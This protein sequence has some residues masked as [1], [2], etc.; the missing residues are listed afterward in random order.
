MLTM[1][2]AVGSASSQFAGLE[3]HARKARI[4]MSRQLRRNRAAAKSA[5]DDCDVEFDHR[6]KGSL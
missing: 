3:Q 5:P 4:G 6:N 1:L 2:G